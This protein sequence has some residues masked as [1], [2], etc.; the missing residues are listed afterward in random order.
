MYGGRARVSHVGFDIVGQA[1][2]TP[3]ALP[4]L[5]RIGDRSSARLRMRQEALP[6]NA[7]EQ[8]AEKVGRCCRL[9]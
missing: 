5:H 3:V 7:A 8:G 1:R 2:I 6:S 9:P 4:F